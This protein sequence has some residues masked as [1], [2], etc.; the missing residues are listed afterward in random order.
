MNI[1]LQEVQEGQEAQAPLA[2]PVP[3]P[4]KEAKVEKPQAQ[5]ADNA[6]SFSAPAKYADALATLHE[7]GYNEDSLSCFLLDQ[8]N[9]NLQKCLRFYLAQQEN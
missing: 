5:A 6:E 3:I 1:I 8:Y 2:V 9:G 4:S 7:L